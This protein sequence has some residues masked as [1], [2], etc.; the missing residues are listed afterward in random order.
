MASYQLTIIAG[1]CGG[2]P[3][4]RYTADGTCVTTFTV[5]VDIGRYVNEEW[6][7]RVQWYRVSCFGK[8]AERINS[9]LSKGMPVLVEGTLSLNRWQDKNTGETK[10]SLE[11]KARKIVP[12]GKSDKSAG[13]VADEEAPSDGDLEPSEMPF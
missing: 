2:D 13:F 6:K 8:T 3:E 9:R 4:M 5:A 7:E 10:S 1:N 11:I 12:F